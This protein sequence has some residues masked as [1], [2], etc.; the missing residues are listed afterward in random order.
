VYRE[1]E[2][3]EAAFC[4]FAVLARRDRLE[5]IL[6]LLPEPRRAKMRA[7]LEEPAGLPPREIRERLARLI[8]SCTAAEFTRAARQTG[9]PLGILPPAVQDWLIAQA[10]ESD[11]RE[12]HQGQA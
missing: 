10:Q 12:D 1:E 6:M 5:Q 8:E 2:A 7:L 9:V 4:Y 3:R 11:G